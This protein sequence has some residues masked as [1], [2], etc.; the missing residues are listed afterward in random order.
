MLSREERIVSEIL[1]SRGLV[2]RDAIEICAK[3]RSPAHT[4]WSLVDALIDSGELERSEGERV[5]EE[6]QALNRSLEPALEGVGRLGE[7][8]RKKM[9]AART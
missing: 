9:A 5:A 8:A 2:G 1:V 3:T 4:G 6:A 7:E